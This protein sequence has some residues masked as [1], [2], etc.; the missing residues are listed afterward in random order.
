LGAHPFTVKANNVKESKNVNIYL[1]AK[2]G[3]AKQLNK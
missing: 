3:I 1:M 2:L